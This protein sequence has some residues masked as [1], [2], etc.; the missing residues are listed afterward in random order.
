[1]VSEKLMKDLNEQIRFEYESAHYY[2]AMAAYCDAEDLPGFADFFKVQ[3]EEERFH[4]MKFYN[5]VNDMDGRVTIGK[6]NEPKNDYTSVLEVFE[7]ALE[8]ERK[9]TERI[10]KL[11]D[12]ATEERE[13]ATISMLKWFI[14][15]QVEEEN[16][17]KDIIARLKRLGDNSH[18]LYMMDKELG[19]RTFTPPANEE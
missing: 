19:Q 5:F 1:M 2:L 3:A 11:M 7:S 12:T 4:A 14:D 16:S 10:Y 18:G 9:V 17:M 8:H 15:E 6:L 13:H